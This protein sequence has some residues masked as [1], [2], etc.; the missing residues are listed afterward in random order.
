MAKSGSGEVCEEGIV[1][2]RGGCGGGGDL[3]LKKL[4]W[5]PDE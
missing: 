5:R 3:E 1:R 2:Y 4:R